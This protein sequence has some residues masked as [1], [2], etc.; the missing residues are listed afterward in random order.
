MNDFLQRYVVLYTKLEK[1]NV[2]YLHNDPTKYQRRTVLR[3]ANKA[4]LYLLN[5]RRD[6][7]K[8]FKSWCVAKSPSFWSLKA[9]WR[10][11][12]AP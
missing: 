12:L 4:W 8:S 9:I 11:L 1:T 2:G 5:S 7:K 3:K 10:D 6:G